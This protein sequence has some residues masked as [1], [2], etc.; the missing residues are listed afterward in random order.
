MSGKKCE[1]KME[2]KHFTI[3]IAGLVCEINCLYPYTYYYCKGFISDGMPN[4]KVDI[5]EE[6]IKREIERAKENFFVCRDFTGKENGRIITKEINENFLENVI[7]YRKIVEASIAFDTFFMHGAVIAV[8][9]RSFMFTAPSGTGKTTHIM[10]W[11]KNTGDAFVVNGD[12]P[13]IKVFDKEVIACGTPWCGKENMGSNKMVPLKAI[14][15]MERSD[16]NQ[17]EEISFAQAYPF[18]LQQTYIPDNVEKAKKTLSLLAQLYGKVRIYQF[19]FN[20]FSD[21]C[22]QTAYDTL[23]RKMA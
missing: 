7:V 12:K 18:L 9:D 1:G 23:I 11:I 4:I 21:D 2:Q 8:Q 17:M 16:I 10:K 15:L 3:K 5:T 19:K 13:L 20:N 22:F 14:I 6:D